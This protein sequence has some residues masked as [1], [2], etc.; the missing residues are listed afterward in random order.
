MQYAIMALLLHPDV[1]AK[2]REEMDAIVGLERAP[3]WNDIPQ[4][5]YLH[6][7]IEEMHRWRPAGPLGLPHEMLQDELVGGILFPKDAIVFTNLCESF[8]RCVEAPFNSLTAIHDRGN[9]PR[10]HVF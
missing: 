5:P 10:S 2:A 3:Q 1:V 4:L 7:V 6:A 8:G 9:V